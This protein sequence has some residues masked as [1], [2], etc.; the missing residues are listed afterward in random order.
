VLYETS[1][2][3]DRR[4]F[5][6]LPDSWSQAGEKWLE[7][8]EV[9]LKACDA[10]VTQRYRSADEMH[11][12]LEVLRGGKSVK[13]LRLLERRLALMTRLLVASDFSPDGRWLVT[14]SFDN[15]AG[16]WEVE[17]GRPLWTW[18]HEA[19]VRSVAF[20][21]DGRYVATAAWDFSTRIWD[22][23]RKTLR[24][25][26]PP[27]KQNSLIHGVRFDSSGRRLLT[28][29]ASGILA[30]W[31]LAPI[32]WRP[33][34]VKDVYSGDGNR[35]LTATNQ[36]LQVWDASTGQAISTPI[37][38]TEDVHTVLLNQD[39]SRALIC[40]KLTGSRNQTNLQARLWD[41]SGKPTRPLG[42]GFACGALSTQP[43][44]ACLSE[45]G[46]RLATFTGQTGAVW[47]TGSGTLL[48]SIHSTQA[49]KRPVFDSSGNYL[50]VGSGTNAEI[51]EATGTKAPRRFSHAS[52]ASSVGHVQFSPDG[53][54]LA[55]S[56]ADTTALPRD[57]QIWDLRTGHK[58][59]PPLNHSDGVWPEQPGP[60]GHLAA[61][62][63]RARRRDF[64]D[65]QRRGP[66]P[67]CAGEQRRQ[68]RHPISERDERR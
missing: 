24:P 12:D 4:K 61:R 62:W 25:A 37:P 30:L 9:L 51:W 5:P 44:T 33:P 11:S 43:W 59:G 66:H 53:A 19:A 27:L 48:R 55:T 56:C 20:S 50:A 49:L 52:H 15:S 1:T 35:F 3:L 39:G 45:N 28:T 26:F 18:L 42:P 34:L 2:G 63:A 16:F 31:D 23:N 10:S 60:F 17:T 57:S 58:I 13:R 38:V 67:D 29:S 6:A 32:H 41:S 21:P 7:L 54:R 22:L 46:E 36:A 8:N 68:S 14:A 47:H 40:V 64:Y 65:R